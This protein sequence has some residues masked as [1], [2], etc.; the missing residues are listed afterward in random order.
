MWW[1]KKGK[2]AERGH[3]GACDGEWS[4]LWK[5]KGVGML[6]EV[7]TLRTRDSV[8]SILCI[9]FAKLMLQFGFYIWIF[10]YIWK[11][12][13]QISTLSI[14][15]TPWDWS[16]PGSSVH[17]DSLGKNI[18]VGCHIL[19][20]PGIEPRSHILQEDSLLSEPPK[21]PWIL[22]WIA[23]PF[24]RGSSWPRNR[25]GISYIAGRFFTSRAT[26]ESH[27]EEIII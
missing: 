16:L 22:E 9:L 11:F 15:K 23:Y 20:N 25:T 5:S 24:S 2:R 8:D 1:R 27:K 21:K 7:Q 12:F 14:K 18:G 19:P 4:C 3:T 17:G 10:F 13:I 26:R 6:K